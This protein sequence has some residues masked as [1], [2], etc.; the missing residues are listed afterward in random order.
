LSSSVTT[1][2]SG[3][4]KNESSQPAKISAD[5]LQ[6]A[7]HSPSQTGLSSTSSLISSFKAS[8]F[9]FFFVFFPPSSSSLSSPSFNSKYS[10]NSSSFSS[11]SASIS[12]TADETSVKYYS[13]DDFVTLILKGSVKYSPSASGS[14]HSPHNSALNFL[15]YAFVAL[16]YSR[17]TFFRL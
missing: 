7:G 15:V 17:I 8:H 11:F 4:S 1:I 5:S 9:L 6:T 13:K 10:F 2:F 12:S 3:S 16:T 14:M